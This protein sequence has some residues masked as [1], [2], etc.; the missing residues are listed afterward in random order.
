MFEKAQ[1]T[2]VLKDR[3]ICIGIGRLVMVQRFAGG[4]DFGR[5]PSKNTLVRERELLKAVCRSLIHWSRLVEI[6]VF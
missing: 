5:L 3:K 1:R 4:V 6:L 2:R